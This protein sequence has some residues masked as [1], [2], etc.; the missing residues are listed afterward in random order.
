MFHALPGIAAIILAAT[1]AATSAQTELQTGSAQR[2]VWDHNGSVVYLVANGASREFYY[3]KPRPGMLDAGARPGS[4]LFRGEVNSGQYVGTA[5]IF[6]P[7]CGPIPFEVKGL[8]LDGDER[9]V[10]TGQAP[11]VGRNCRA[12]TSYTSNLEFRRAK[13]DESANQ[14]LEALTAPQP[15]ST[16]SKPELQPDVSGPRGGE[17]SSPATAPRPTKNE[18]P[19]SA[20]DVVPGS[21][22]VSASTGPISVTNDAQPAKDLNKF[23]WGA[24]FMVMVVWVLIKLFGKTFI[25]MK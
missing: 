9:I 3:Q 4:L 18:M 7:L 10:L 15:P 2:T 20:K 6:N 25:G 24:A 13:L 19:V 5:Y 1:L 22:A 17:V 11:R 16:T 12:Y 8:S 23:L 14:S 21:T